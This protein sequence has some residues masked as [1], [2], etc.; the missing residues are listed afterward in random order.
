MSGQIRDTSLTAF[1]ETPL[2]VDNSRDGQFR[3]EVNGK[4]VIP[5]EFHL[6]RESY[7]HFFDDSQERQKS[8]KLRFWSE[9]EIPGEDGYTVSVYVCPPRDPHVSR[10]EMFVAQNR[11]VD[12]RGEWYCKLS[13]FD[14]SIHEY[15]DGRLVNIE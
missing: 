10:Q 9:E 13:E 2:D 3:V 8:L 5:T 6:E 7:N 12:R 1:P 15:E 4:T 11:F 14:R